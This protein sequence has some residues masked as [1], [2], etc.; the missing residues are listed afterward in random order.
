M[1]KYKVGDKVLMQMVV[2]EVTNNDYA[3]IWVS[4]ERNDTADGMW[5][6]EEQIDKYATKTYE[7]GLTDAWKILEHIQ[8]GELS[9]N[10]IR[11]IWGMD[12]FAFVNNFTD[13]YT[14]QE[15]IKILEAYEESK[16]IN[17]GDVVVYPN[18]SREYVVINTECNKAIST[19]LLD[20]VILSSSGWKKTGRHID[21]EHI[22]EQ[23]RG[24]E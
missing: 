6:N 17:V 14:P 7:D 4:L 20:S 13:K 1:S 12:D 24:N 19:D 18:N 3:Q 8:S 21:I 9:Q 15:A 2:D 11:N 16:V 23:I 5:L 22:L 10:D